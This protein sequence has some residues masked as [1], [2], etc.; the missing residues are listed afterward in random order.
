MKNRELDEGSQN[1]GEEQ[2]N[3]LDPLSGRIL[4]DNKTEINTEM[5]SS[6]QMG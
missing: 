4:N 2:R 6:V 3:R 1:N 5:K